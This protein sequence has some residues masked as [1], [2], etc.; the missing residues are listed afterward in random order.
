LSRYATKR[1]TGL[2][3]IGR[4]KLSSVHP[5]LREQASVY[6]EY[7]QRLSRASEELLR[8]YKK[9]I[10]GQQFPTKRVADIAIDLFVGLCVLSRVTSLIE[11]RGADKC[12]QEISIAHIFTQQAK[13]R[14]NQNIRRLIQNE[15]DEMRTLS[16]YI[17]GK[18]G[19][20]W[21]TI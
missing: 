19:Y 18:G 8:R 3:S 10:I 15:D 17:V 4:E 1:V 5:A 20:P 21:D 14:M 7:T 13:R 6:E 12:A 2:T 9:E 11:E 16:D